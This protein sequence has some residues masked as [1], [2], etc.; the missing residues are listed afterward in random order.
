[1][2]NLEREVHD[3]VDVHRTHFRLPAIRR[4]IGLDPLDLAASLG[5]LR[6][7]FDVYAYDAIDPGNLDERVD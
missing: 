6:L 3:C 4:K 2:A 5:R 1:L 7:G